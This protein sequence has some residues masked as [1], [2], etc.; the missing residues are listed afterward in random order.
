M[1][2]RY[3]RIVRIFFHKSKIH[4][5]R[6]TLSVFSISLL[7]LL[8]ILFLRTR[9]HEI[10]RGSYNLIIF[11]VDTLRQDHLGC[12]GYSRNTSPN[13]DRFSK[14]SVLF[15]N[16]ISNAYLTPLSQMSIFKSQHPRDFIRDTSP[17]SSTLMDAL[18]SNGYR[19]AA[20]GSSPEFSEY[21]A[22]RFR[23]P[24]SKVLT[25]SFDHY[26]IHDRDRDIPWEA[27]HWLQNNKSELFFL[28]IPVG[29]AL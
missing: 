26:F 29:T 23:F 18:R 9:S 21:L 6:I 13:L 2:Q 27:I 12:Y 16:F 1:V 15:E 10:E 4:L 28:W 3:S 8:L 20:I 7:I 22:S 25:N 19:N 17:Q 5:K 14:E 24:F 11:S